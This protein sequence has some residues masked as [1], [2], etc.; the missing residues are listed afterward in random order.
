MNRYYSAGYGR[1]LTVDPFGG[2]ARVRNPGSMNRYTYALGDP[3]NGYD[4]GGLC[5]DVIAGITM[6]PQ[7]GP[8]Q[9][10][11]SSLGADSAYPYQGEDKGTSVLAVENQASDSTTAALNSILYALNTNSGLIDIVAYSGGAQAFT[12]AYNQLTEAQQQ[13]IGEILYISPGANGP[14]AS[15]PGLTDVVEGSG[16]IDG[17]AMAGT[18]VPFGATDLVTNCDHTDLACLLRFSATELKIMMKNGTCGNQRVFT[19]T[20]PNGMS[21]GGGGG[22]G[23]GMAFGTGPGWEAGAANAFALWMLSIQTGGPPDISI[24]FGVN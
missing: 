22:F 10:L 5:T 24:S 17:L 3:V 6:G 21:A 2:S 19:R 8:F 23:G 7:R 9:S 12:S 4:P 15:N 13:R 20:Q 11:A 18:L 14:L 16:V 1:F